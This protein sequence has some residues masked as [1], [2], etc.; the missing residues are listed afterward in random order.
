MPRAVCLWSCPPAH[1]SRSISNR[2]AHSNDAQAPAPSWSL[3]SNG[4]GAVGLGLWD[5]HSFL[6]PKALQALTMGRVRSE[7]EGEG[8]G[9][10]ECDGEGEGDG[11][12]AGDG[13][14]EGLLSIPQNTRAPSGFPI[15]VFP[16]T[17]ALPIC[18]T[19]P[20]MAPS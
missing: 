5:F 10:G 1:W 6:P 2:S 3:G 4:P 9:E 11:E 14:G 16:I 8:D 20:S 18:S 13:E 15:L 12:G 7:G 17:S 19:L